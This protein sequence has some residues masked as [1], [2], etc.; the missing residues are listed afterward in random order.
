MKRILAIAL[1]L[2]MSATALAGE[3]PTNPLPPPCTENCST[4]T[5]PIPTVEA[6][7]LL[8]GLV[9]LVR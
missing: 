6:F 9:R 2:T 5:T 7:V 4:T 3:I 8:L 1:L